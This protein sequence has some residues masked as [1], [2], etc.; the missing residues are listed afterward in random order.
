MSDTDTNEAPSVD[1]PRADKAQDKGA[2][3]VRWLKEIAKA[4]DFE[5]KWRERADKVVKRYRDEREATED[6]ENRASQ[7]NIL[8]ANTQVLKG[9]MYQRTPV[10]D[11]RRR[12]A[13]K[14]PVGRQAALILQRALSY[15]NDSYDFDG[16]MSN[17]VEDALLP[18]RGVP[19]VKYKPTMSEDGQ[20]VVY[21][22][23]CAEYVEWK[24]FRMSPAT[25]WGKVRWIAFG[26]LLTRGELVKQFGEDAGSKCALDW[27]PKDKETEPDYARALVWMV[28]DKTSRKLIAVCKGY[29]DAP[30]LDVDDPL[31]LEGFWPIPKPLYA[32]TETT[33]NMI[34]VPE[35]IQYQDL[36]IELDAVTERIS[37][38]VDALRRRGI[39][40]SSQPELARLA[41][42]GDNQFIPAENF[43]ALLEKGGIDKV[44]AELPID[45]LA[46]VILSLY[47][48]RDQ[49][50]GLLYEVTGISDIVRGNTKANETLGAQQLKA[51]Y[52]GSRINTRQKE[53]AKLARDIMRLEAEIIAEHFSPETLKQMTGPELWFIEQNV[54]GLDGRPQM[55]KVDATEQIMQLLRDDK[56]RGFRVDIET[57][58]TIQ[59]HA[60]EEQKNRVEFLG[61]VTKYIAEVSPLVAQGAMPMDV[62]KEFLSFSA[63]GFKVSP[64]LEEAIDKLGGDA[65][66]Q[67]QGK[68]RQQELQQAQQQAE[69]RKV[70]AEAEKAEAEARKVQIEVEILQQQLAMGAAPVAAQQVPGNVGVPQAP[71][72]MQMLPQGSPMGIQQPAPMQG[73]VL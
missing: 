5:E 23:T 2:E 43:A 64:Q 40:D 8:Y 70:N 13:D 15:T 56:L 16:V 59:P 66:E 46:Q 32:A 58:S 25:R 34:P 37:K 30:L 44:F 41:D 47:Q 31:R 72:G 1:E 14:D 51:Q 29:P 35:Y 54:P 24:W 62:A 65:D 71:A 20:Q 6:G 67:K 9:Q 10:P 60:E 28:W 18:G 19:I 3:V 11:V 4:S 52:S 49:I 63:R 69:M 33:C 21:E 55:Q 50:K 73:G 39:Y 22:E 42:A 68:A 45:R 48:Q 57:D 38:L 27:H 61:A 7:F 17:V 53:V 36:A 12:F 26:E